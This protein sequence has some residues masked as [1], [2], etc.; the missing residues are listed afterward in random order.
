MDFPGLANNLQNGAGQKMRLLMVYQ[1]EDLPSSR[2]R[3]ME[4]VPFLQK[5]GF[6]CE[7]ISYRNLKH[8]NASGVDVMILQKCGTRLNY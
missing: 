7:L 3:I 2:I 4:L 5:Y 8:W 1:D 6:E